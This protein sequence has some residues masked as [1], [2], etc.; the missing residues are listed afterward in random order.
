[1]TRAVHR[2]E[3][4]LLFVNLELEHV[5]GIVLPVTRSFPEVGVEDIGRSDLG[6]TTL[7]IFV[8]DK[9]HQG[10]V[11]SHTHRQEEGTSR[12]KVVKDE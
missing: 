6:E 10:V 2:L 1:M 7:E 11:D 4:K 5:F 3:S 12:R 9:C 8:L